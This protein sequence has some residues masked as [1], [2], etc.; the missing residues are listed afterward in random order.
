M[1]AVYQSTK[2]RRGPLPGLRHARWQE[3]SQPSRCGTQASAPLARTQLSIFQVQLALQ[4]FQQ[5]SEAQTEVERWL[6]G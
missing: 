1:T 3:R 4:S 2:P 5:A 6:C